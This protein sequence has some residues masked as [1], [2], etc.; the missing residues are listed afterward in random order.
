MKL[1]VLLVVVLFMAACS[2]R[3]VYENV[4]ISKR[5]E[6]ATLPQPQYESCMKETSKTYNEYERERKELLDDEG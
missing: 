1:S 6:C 2:N 3:A 5:N 4:Q